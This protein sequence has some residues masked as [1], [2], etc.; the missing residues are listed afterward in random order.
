MEFAI[1]TNYVVKLVRRAF[2]G[3][4]S[5]RFQ[6]FYL[7]RIRKLFAWSVILVGI[8]KTPQMLSSAIDCSLF[9]VCHLPYSTLVLAPLFFA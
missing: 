7:M 4:I 6:L 9:P 8:A 2:V 1:P 5:F 3:N